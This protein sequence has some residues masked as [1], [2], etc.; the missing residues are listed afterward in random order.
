MGSQTDSKLNRMV[1]RQIDS[2]LN[3]MVLRQTDSKL[4]RMVLCLR[5][6]Q[7][8]RSTTPCS[9]FDCT[10]NKTSAVILYTG[11]IHLGSGA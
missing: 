8:F 1:L 9:W 6:L 5:H 10:E 3:R 4:N 2:K 7:A 11:Q